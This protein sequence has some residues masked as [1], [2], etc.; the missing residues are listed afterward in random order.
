[1][2]VQGGIATAHSPSPG[3]VCRG[4]DLGMGPNTQLLG[5][6]GWGQQGHRKQLLATAA[7]TAARWPFLALASVTPATSQGLTC[8]YTHH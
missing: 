8:T 3:S 2:L 6:S 4:G 7:G 1:M 5:A